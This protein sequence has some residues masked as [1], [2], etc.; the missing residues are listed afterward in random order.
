MREAERLFGRHGV[1]GVSLRDIVRAAGH[2]NESAVQYHFGS[3]RKLVDAVVAGR[4]ERIEARRLAMLAEVEAGGATRDP[5]RL[6]ACVVEPLVD[7]VL[8]S[9][10]GE[11]YIRFLAQAITRPGFDIVG[12]VAQLRLPGMLGVTRHLRALAKRTPPQV[13]HM[14]ERMAIIA[15]VTGLAGW[16]AGPRR[17]GRKRMTRELIDAGILLVAAP[18]NRR[19]VAEIPSKP[20]AI[21]C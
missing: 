19:I 6:M 12:H 10:G 7:E 13:Q 18:C 16:V 4:L 14:R 15:M 8:E 2:R 17:V 20:G 21:P 11:D 5:R 1:E 3:K 9:K